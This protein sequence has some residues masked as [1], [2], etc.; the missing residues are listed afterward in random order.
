MLPKSKVGAG[1][2]VVNNNQIKFY[3]T[4]KKDLRQMK[5]RLLLN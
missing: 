1:F 3:K 5:Q 4:I 2:F